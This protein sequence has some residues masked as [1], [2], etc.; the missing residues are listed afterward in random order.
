MSYNEVRIAGFGGQGIILA[1][2]ITGQAAAI[3]DGKNAT[4][5]KAYGPEARGGACS[6]QLIISDEQIYYPYVK[7]PDTLVVMSQEAFVKF[8]DELREG[9][10]LI[11]DE[12][13]VKKGD[14]EAV[15]D[16]FNLH[17]IPSTR[18]AEEMGRRIIANIVML[19][20]F[21]ATTGLVSASAMESA[22]E[23]Y[24]PKGTEALNLEAFRRGFEYV[25]KPVLK[26]VE[27]DE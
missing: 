15:A 3:Y 18:F 7:E 14:Y 2:A 22:I 11:V 24:V 19:G 5:V 26:E 6:A 17:A 1:G 27:A 16:K 21:T 12:D 4:L 25:E 23:K 20:F 9:G 10:F 13:L 8:V